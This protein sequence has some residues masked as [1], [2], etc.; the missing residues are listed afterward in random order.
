MKKHPSENILDYCVFYKDRQ[1]PPLHKTEAVKRALIIDSLT[2]NEHPLNQLI[3]QKQTFVPFINERDNLGRLISSES[4]HRKRKSDASSIFNSPKSSHHFLTKNS[5]SNT[6]SLCENQLPA[7]RLKLKNLLGCTPENTELIQSTLFASQSEFKQSFQFNSKHNQVSLKMHKKNN[8]LQNKLPQFI[9]ESKIPD[10]KLIQ[11]PTT[12]QATRFYQSNFVIE[13]FNLNKIPEYKMQYVILMETM[14]KFQIDF[15]KNLTANER[16]RTFVKLDKN[17]RF[18]LSLL[19]LISKPHTYV[20]CI[21]FVLAKYTIFLDTKQVQESTF[22]IDINST[23]LETNKTL[24]LQNF[25][26]YQYVGQIRVLSQDSILK[27]NVI[28]DTGSSQMWLPSVNCQRCNK[29]QIGIVCEQPTCIQSQEQA[30]ITY[31]V[32]ALIGVK[33]LGMFSINEYF[34]ESQF[35]LVDEVIGMEGAIYDGVVGLQQQSNHSFIEWPISFYYNFEN[36]NRQSSI[37]FGGYDDSLFNKEIRYVKSDEQWIIYS[38]S[39]DINGIL[40]VN[41]FVMIDSGSSLLIFPQNILVNLQNVFK[42][43]IWT[44]I[45]KCSCPTNDIYQFPTIKVLLDQQ[46]FSLEPQFYIHTNNHEPICYILISNIRSHNDQLM[47]LGSPFMRKYYT[48]FDKLNSQI[49]LVE[50]IQ[51]QESNSKNL[52][53]NF[54]TLI[55]CTIIAIGIIKIVNYIME[56]ELKKQNNQKS[57]MV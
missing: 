49:G 7:T 39:I 22:L 5:I 14:S 56:Y 44:E 23:K 8:S 15:L 2:N 29:N 42:N 6:S 54:F 21:H 17:R 48:I 37:T 41:H 57:Q 12:P 18:K 43:C 47:I 24:V 9:K 25:Y 46:E 31:H 13:M 28:F 51:Y 36:S 35:I 50:S 1:L 16:R 55:G 33:C 30:S 32:G 40:G 19:L 34:D 45:I 53:K 38:Q 3:Q 26:N 20:A 11:L 10:I 4:Y 27:F 52:L